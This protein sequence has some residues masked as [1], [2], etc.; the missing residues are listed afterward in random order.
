M[1]DLKEI[2]LKENEV[3]FTGRIDYYS[4][5]WN[6]WYKSD[7]ITLTWDGSAGR[8][9]RRTKT[10][11]IKEFKTYINKFNSGGK[12]A[13]Y[14]V[15]HLPFTYPDGKTK[16][17]VIKFHN[18]LAQIAKLPFYRKGKVA[19]HIDGNTLNNDL[20]NLQWI[21]KGE[22]TRLG[23]S[24]MSKEKKKER[25]AKYSEGVAAGHAKGNYKNHLDKL[26]EYMRDKF[27]KAKI[28]ADRTNN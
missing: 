18:A 25:I 24:R 8:V 23:W 4:K 5:K 14:L 7:T 6:K 12:E 28:E 26:H 16:T 10:G 3:M 17:T 1:K 11:Q 19:D 13:S 22:N 2:K 27:K 15:F 9:F 21:T 20:D